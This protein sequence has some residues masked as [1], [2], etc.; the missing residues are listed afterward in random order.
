MIQGWT[1]QMI[2][3]IVVSARP[4]KLRGQR[5]HLLLRPEPRH[6][7]A[8]RVCEAGWGIEDADLVGL[9]QWIATTKAWGRGIRCSPS[10]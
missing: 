8:G 3:P 2:R 7:R 10:S 5:R 6:P 9:D 1:A 4:R